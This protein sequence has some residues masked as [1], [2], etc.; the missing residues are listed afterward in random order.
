MKR[1][2]KCNSVSE[3]YKYSAW[4][5]KTS[6]HVLFDV[7]GRVQE[8]QGSVATVIVKAGQDLSARSATLECLVCGHKGGVDA[9]KTVAIS[10][11]SGAPA[12]AAVDTAFKLVVPG[13]TSWEG[14]LTVDLEEVD[15]F[16]LMV[17]SGRSLRVLDPHAELARQWSILCAA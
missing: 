5:V 12:N 2:P 10:W 1:C 6:G 13:V 15:E 7:R 16:T 17:D 8:L 3:R 4:T 9:F 11:L 14:R